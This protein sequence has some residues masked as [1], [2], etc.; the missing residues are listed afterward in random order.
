MTTPHNSAIK[1]NIAETVLLPGDPLRAKFIAENFLQDVEQFNAVRNMFG[2]TGTY[3]G[4]RVSVMGTGM[5][6]ASIG[7]YSYELIHMYGVKNLIRIGSCGAY[8]ENL[9]LF[10]I[11]LAIGASTDTN[12]AY[13]YDLPGTFSAT[14]SWE[15]LSNAKK[16]AD[17]NGIH[18]VVGNIVTSDVF[19]H[20]SP[21]DWKRWAKMG[22]VAAEMESYALYCNASRAGV[23]ALTILTVSDSI[24]RQSETTPEQ[25]EKGFKDM[26]KIALELA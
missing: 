3:N 10:D 5:G 19:Y 15:L 13:Q 17:E 21:E 26:M 16:I 9:K 25:R 6:C 1:G 20:D 11:V 4:K 14:A 18:T 23:N 12:F 8:D 22:I 2:Y 7:I 24:A